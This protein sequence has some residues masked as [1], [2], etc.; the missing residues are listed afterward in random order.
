[1][2]SRK[3]EGAGRYYGALAVRVGQGRHKAP[4][5][6]ASARISGAL[7][8]SRCSFRAFAARILVGSLLILGFSAALATLLPASRAAR[9]SPITALRR[10]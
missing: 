8:E 7:T 9:M 5:P 4:A 6:P 1:L 10:D 2:N 3:C